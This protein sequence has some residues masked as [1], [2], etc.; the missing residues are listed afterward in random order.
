M[1]FPVSVSLPNFFISPTFM[2]NFLVGKKFC[3]H[4]KKMILVLM[5]F[6]D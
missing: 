4:Q 6:V 5:N 1:T 2:L 3:V